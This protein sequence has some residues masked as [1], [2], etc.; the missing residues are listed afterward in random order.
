MQNLPSLIGGMGDLDSIL[1]HLIK[2]D[3]YFVGLLNTL[4]N[5]LTR[6]CLSRN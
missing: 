4:Q 5:F 6:N 2:L 3:Q 1:D